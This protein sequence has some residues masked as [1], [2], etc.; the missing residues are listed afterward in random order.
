MELFL[1]LYIGSVLGFC[2]GLY[3]TY[4]ADCVTIKTLKKDNE[5]MRND[6]KTYFGVY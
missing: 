1:G 2:F 4:T 5:N 6:L 3:V